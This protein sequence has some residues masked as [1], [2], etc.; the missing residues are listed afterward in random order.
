M[1]DQSQSEMSVRNRDMKDFY[2]SRVWKS[3]R[4]CNPYEVVRFRHI[5]DFLGT[6]SADTVLDAGC[7]GGTYTRILAMAQLLIAVDVSTNAVKTAK[8]SLVS[9]TNV[10]FIVCDLEHLPIRNMTVDKIACID[11]LEHVERPQKAVNE[12]SRILRSHGQM[13]LFTACGENRFT[14]EYMLKPFFGKLINSIRSTL[15]HVSI[16]T[17]QS[18]RRMSSQDFKIAHIEYMHHWVG[19]LFKFCWDAT[20]LNSLEGHQTQFEPSASSLSRILWLPLEA[21]YKLFKHRS[22]GSEIIVHATKKERGLN[23]LSNQ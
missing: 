19:W 3:H 16:F 12:I 11:V 10:L 2:E 9:E 22:H 23:K 14:L 7:G 8:Q 17:T 1:S 21:E 13:L 18:V 15:G 5:L 4:I 6:E 20:H